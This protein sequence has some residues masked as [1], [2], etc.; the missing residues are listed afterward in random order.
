MPGCA[1]R[2]S[3]ILAT[4]GDSAI[5]IGDIDLYREVS[6]RPGPEKESTQY[7]RA[8]LDSLVNLRLLYLEGVR[9]GW[10]RDA[11]MIAEIEHLKDSFVIDALIQQEVTQKVSVPERE[12]ADYYRRQGTLVHARHIL[13]N[14]EREAR[15][16]LAQLRRGTGFEEMARERSLDVRTARRGG[17]LGFFPWGLGP[18][19]QVAFSLQPGEIS[20]VFRSSLG[21]HILK[22]EERKQ[23]PQRP[24]AD[25]REEMRANLLQGKQS[26]R[27]QAFLRALMSSYLR[28]DTPVATNL[29]RRF[30]LPGSSVFAPAPSLG[31]ADSGR[32]IARY[33]GESWTVRDLLE[34]ANAYG[35]QMA[36]LLR[37]P[38]GI[39]SFAER[40]LENT[41]LL[42]EACRRGLDRSADT[43]G[44]MEEL[45]RQMVVNRVLHEEVLDRAH[46]DSSEIREYYAAHRSEMSLPERVRA[47]QILVRT[48]EAAQEVLTELARGADFSW[49]AA[50]RSVHFTKGVGGDLGYFPRGRFPE[51]EQEAFSLKPGQLSPVIRTERGF[52]VLKVIAHELPR[53]RLLSEAWLEIEEKLKRQKEGELLQDLLARLRGEI[54]IHLFPHNL[55][56][57]DQPRL[58]SSR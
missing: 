17:D 11:D 35:P 7:R 55:R 22:V 41:L 2:D 6:A 10:D 1:R 15:Q 9:Q 47:L 36:P 49:L 42:A 37:T 25:V 56:L 50:K 12:V 44:W 57:L 20:E 23:V 8:L 51:I 5:T 19:Q 13:F 3:V 18:I 16:A 4:V 28:F 58:A 43:R 38:Q 39:R 40:A 48:P 29:A 34:R 32:V 33:L 26:V 31:A 27:S 54:R 30:S 52:V 21:Y 46:V 14:S 53:G 24:F 45:W